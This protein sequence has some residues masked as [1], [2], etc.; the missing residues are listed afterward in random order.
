[1]G[2]HQHLLDTYPD[3]TYAGFCKKQENAESKG[4]NMTSP[5]KLQEGSPSKMNEESPS[6]KKEKEDPQ[7]AEM[8]DKINK[9]DEK[10]DK[11]IEEFMEKQS[12]LDQFTRVVGYN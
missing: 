9:I 1:M 11:E 5:D 10:R 12:K 6:K 8:K 7:V 2:T 3:G 4:E